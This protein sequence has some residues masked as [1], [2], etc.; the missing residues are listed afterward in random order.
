MPTVLYATV[1]CERCGAAFRL[2]QLTDSERSRVVGAVRAGQ[3][4]QAI[5]LLR[6]LAGFDLCD[7]K[8]LEMHLT[9]TKGT[10]VRCRSSLPASGQVL[11]AKCHSL[12]IDW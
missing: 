12:N 11:C 2:P 8:A 6:K 4:A 9:R 7:G 10:C 1:S 3:H 5:Q